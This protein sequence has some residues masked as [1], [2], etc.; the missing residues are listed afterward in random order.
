MSDTYGPE[1]FDDIDN[2]IFT[3]EKMVRTLA[4]VP[5]SD[6][7]VIKKSD[8]ERLIKSLPATPLRVIK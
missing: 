7:I 2:G 6:E 4:L 1:D 8:Y 5:K 3:P